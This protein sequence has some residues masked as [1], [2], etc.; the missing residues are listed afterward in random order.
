MRL[1][2]RAGLVGLMATVVIGAAG[3]APTDSTMA[4]PAPSESATQEPSPAS[5]PTSTEEAPTPA[6]ESSPAQAAFAPSKTPT[7]TSSPTPDA[8]VTMDSGQNEAKAAQI[9]AQQ[10][11][12]QSESSSSTPSPAVGGG[13]SAAGTSGG[14]GSA[15]SAKPS[16]SKP[17]ADVDP[18][19]EYGEVLCISKSTNKMHFMKEGEI[20][21][22]V[23]V[24]FGKESDPKK[25]TREGN[26]LV[27]RK[28]VDHVSNLYDSEMPFSM[29]FS[30]G[31]AVHYSTDF[32]ARGY[33]GNSHGCVN[34]RDR[35][36][37]KNIFDQVK[38]M[39][40]RVV[41]YS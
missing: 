1:R 36:T 29:F 5:E 2:Y 34:V 41:V 37:L 9:A 33:A 18:R 6:A 7:P 19:C 24:R 16:S 11:A 28:E 32:A 17:K 14:A 15:P 8:E 22:T 39:E 30:G 12:K 13:G 23:D 38:V 20:Q 26:F 31:Q 40:T 25:R 27:F 21:A 3:C 35:E 4:V 10:K